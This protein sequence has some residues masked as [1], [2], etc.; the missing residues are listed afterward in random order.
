MD[1]QT[2]SHK[3]ALSNMAESIWKCWFK[4]FHNIFIYVLLV[5]AIISFL[6]KHYIDMVVIFSVFRAVG[7]SMIRHMLAHSFFCEDVAGILSLLREEIC[8]FL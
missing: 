4:H 2:Q 6:L 7:R 3:N 8:L 1:S 5:I